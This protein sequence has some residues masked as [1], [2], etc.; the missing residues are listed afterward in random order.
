[1]RTRAWVAAAALLVAGCSHAQPTAVTAPET[2][3]AV[4][5]AVPA[6]TAL[7]R[8]GVPTPQ[9]VKRSDTGIA[10]ATPAGDTYV[11]GGHRC[12]DQGLLWAAS[13]PSGVNGWGR[14]GEPF[15]PATGE[16]AGNPAYGAAYQACVG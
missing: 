8:A 12:N 2:T 7:F 9:P 6:C 3:P 14:A 15:H 13:P 10:C 1:M 4:A 11:I 16:I 5:Q